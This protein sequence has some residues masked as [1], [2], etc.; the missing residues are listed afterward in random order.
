[1][2]REPL[3]LEIEICELFKAYGYKNPKKVLK[4]A[5]RLLKERTN[6]VQ[7]CMLKDIIR[8]P[9]PALYIEQCIVG[10]EDIAIAIDSFIEDGCHGMI[11][12]KG[13]AY[14]VKLNVPSHWVDGRDRWSPEDE[15][16]LQFKAAENWMVTNEKD[17][18]DG[19]V[20][21][22]A[23]FGF[24]GVPNDIETKFVE[25]TTGLKRLPGTN[26]YY[27]EAAK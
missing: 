18:F 26:L 5:V 16:D 4:Y 13:T 12:H 9:N 25:D 17:H 8:A 10:V 23:R 21:L 14:P 24:T 19:K 22:F 2:I 20:V 27:T 6:E 3:E 11:L 7:I 15:R 1:M